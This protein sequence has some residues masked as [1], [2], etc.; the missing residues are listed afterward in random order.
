MRE[1]RALADRRRGR[2]CRSI[3]STMIMGDIGD[4]PVKAASVEQLGLDRR[5][6][7]PPRCRGDGAPDLL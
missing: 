7:A 5:R 2:P 4:A 3:A 1:R 6:V